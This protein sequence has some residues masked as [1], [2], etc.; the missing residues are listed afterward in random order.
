MLKHEDC[1]KGLW[2]LIKQHWRNVVY[3]EATRC[4]I[5]P[6][7]DNKAYQQIFHERYRP[8]V[9]AAGFTFADG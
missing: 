1:C 4:G 6:D 2:K 7:I 5:W 3:V 8:C 9:S